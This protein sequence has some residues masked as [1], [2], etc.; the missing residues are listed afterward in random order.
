MITVNRSQTLY[1]DPLIR[2]LR[3]KPGDKELSIVSPFQ[4][5]TRDVIEHSL[6]INGYQVHLS[7]TAGIRQLDGSDESFVENEGIRRALDR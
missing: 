5:T 7:D 2:F 3:S 1:L 6:E 4:G